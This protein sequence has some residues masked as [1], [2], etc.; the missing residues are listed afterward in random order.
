MINYVLIGHPFNVYNQFLLLTSEHNSF[1]LLKKIKYLFCSYTYQRFFALFDINFRIQALNTSISDI[2][3][4]IFP[5]RNETLLYLCT[6]HIRRCQYI[7]TASL[8][9]GERKDA[10]SMINSRLRHIIKTIN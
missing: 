8:P 3:F 9:V 4:G 5:Y 10:L 1:L 6:N 7:L 2:A